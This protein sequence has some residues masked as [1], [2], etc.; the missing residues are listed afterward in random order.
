M[1]VELDGKVIEFT[2]AMAVFRLLEELSLSKEAHLVV[3]NGALVTEDC[4][5]RADDTVKLVRVISGG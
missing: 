5:L 4:K 1:K 3:V 2:K